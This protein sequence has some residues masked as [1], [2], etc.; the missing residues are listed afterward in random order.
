MEWKNI[1]T[2]MNG[3]EIKIVPLGR[4]D[5]NKAFKSV[6]SLEVKM[7]NTKNPMYGKSHSDDTKKVMSEKKKGTNHP[8]FE[9]YYYFKNAL[10]GETFKGCTP[11]ELRVNALLP[12]C[13]MT[14]ARRCK[15]GSE[16][17]WFGK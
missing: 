11:D 16:N 1:I 9:G 8:K 3:E 10:T 13:A 5:E 17:Y 12:C 15:K 2:S 6:V 7:A 4:V 14:V